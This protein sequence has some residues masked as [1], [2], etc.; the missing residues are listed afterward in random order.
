MKGLDFTKCGQPG[1]HAVSWILPESL[2]SKLAEL[3]PAYRL[4]PSSSSTVAQ[5][6]WQA[7]G[8]QAGGLHSHLCKSKIRRPCKF[9]GKCWDVSMCEYCH[10]EG[11]LAEKSPP[12]KPGHTRF[13]QQ[14]RLPRQCLYCHEAAH[15][16][17]QRS[18][19]RLHPQNG[20]FEVG[21]KSASSQVSGRPR[22]V[23]RGLDLVCW[24][25]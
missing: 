11:H 12:A 1:T 18:R 6:S 20:A 15:R 21:A 24:R 7:A 22:P 8:S 2:D 5:P 14:R 25:F 23:N 9:M 16:Y 3:F 10:D 17:G 19:I 13:T 4:L